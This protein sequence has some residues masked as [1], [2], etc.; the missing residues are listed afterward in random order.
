MDAREN[1]SE[2]GRTCAFIGDLSEIDIQPDT[3]REVWLASSNQVVC[4]VGCQ[5]GIDITVVGPLAIP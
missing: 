2:I 5:I 1:E 3:I 4:Q